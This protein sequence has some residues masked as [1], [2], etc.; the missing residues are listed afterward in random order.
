MVKMTEVSL[1]ISKKEQILSG[2]MQTFLKNGYTRTSMDQIASVS[3]VSKNTIYS[4]FG[5]KEGLFT[6][7]IEEIASKRFEMVYGGLS[8]QESPELVLRHIATNLLKNILNDPEYINFLRVLIA[9]SE[10]FPHLAQL[11]IRSLPQKALETLTEHLTIHQQELELLNPQATARIFLNSLM[12]YVLTQKVLGGE[13][14]IP[15]DQEVLINSLVHL[16]CRKS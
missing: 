14:I 9:E 7:L 12:G 2:A 11:F 8:L 6:V 13:E 10:H 15:L 16:I 3:G 5:D 4:H 1:N